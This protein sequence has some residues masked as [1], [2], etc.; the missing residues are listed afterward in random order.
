M[1]TFHYVLIAGIISLAAMPTDSQA[2]T[3]TKRADVRE[4]AQRARIVEGR[5]DGEVTQGEA[6]ALKVEQRHIRRAERRAKSD[7]EVTRV[8][9]RRLERKQDRA[10]RHIKRAKHNK[11][12]NN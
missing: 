11:I 12:D 8:E 4:R 7:G 1:K 3:K 5:K 9:K 10:S 6:A 2:Q